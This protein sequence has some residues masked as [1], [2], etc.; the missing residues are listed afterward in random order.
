MLCGIFGEVSMRHRFVGPLLLLPLFTLF[1]RQQAINQ[2]ATS[3][4]APGEQRFAALVLDRQGVPIRDLHSD[5]FA[6]E[7]AGKP[8]PLQVRV[9]PSGLVA[10]GR[11]LVVVVIDTM[12]T[13][14]EEEKDLRLNAGKYLSSCAK[15]DLPV[16]LFLFSRYGALVPVHEYTT[17]SATLTA[18]LKQADAEMR[19]KTESAGATLEV[20]AEAQRLLDF[21]RGQ[22]KFASAKAME[23]Y[24]GAMLGGFR[25]VAQYVSGI[26]GRK[27]LVWISSVFPFAVEEKH[28]RILS[29][30]T[31]SRAAGDLIYPNLLTEDQVRQL[32]VVWKDSIGV[33]Q[34]TELALYPV[35]TRATA[36]VPLNPEVI[37]SMTSLARMTG[38]VEVHS[39]GDFFGQFAELPEQSRAAYELLL[40]ADAGRDCRSDWCPLKIKVKRP[41]ARVFAP[42]GFFPESGP[43]SPQTPLPLAHRGDEPNPGPNAIPFTVNWKPEEVA[44]A[45]KKIAFVVAF[46]P[47]AGLPAEGSTEL[48]VE[49]MVHA[50][51]E[52]AE[53]QAVSFGANKQL[54]EST[55][56]EIRSKGFV[57]NNSIELEPGDYSI[58]F[59]VHDKTSGRLGILKVPLKVG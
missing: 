13:R 4:S 14:W 16:S 11:G 36:T 5:D 51:I 18:A 57:L 42:Q 46:G 40:P 25:S 41:G 44:G 21:Y 35:L 1:F 20:S 47:G 38:G 23:E 30:T 19:H 56:A 53:I 9:P 58:R 12:H 49:V 28:G 2:T 10:P 24:P 52:G 55:L 22:G 17:S 45:K 48:N 39:V 54:P 37:N 34:R 6:L 8:E 59:V 29:P 43:A 7:V 3:T 27:S 32:Q 15:R 50:F 31:T 33:A 26:E